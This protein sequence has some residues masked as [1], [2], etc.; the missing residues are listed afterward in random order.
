MHPPRFLPSHRLLDWPDCFLEHH[1]CQGKIVYPIRLLVSERGNPTFAETLVRMRCNKCGSK[2]KGPVYLCAS[3]NRKFQGGGAPD[4][5]IEL[6][7][8][9]RD[10]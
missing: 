5:S 7:P 3:H 10:R 1:C 8:A 9:P 2:L 4:W 6:I